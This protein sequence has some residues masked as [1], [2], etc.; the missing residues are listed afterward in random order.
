MKNI[1]KEERIIVALDVDS[2][3]KEKAL[4]ETLYPRVKVF[5]IGFQLFTA[6]GPDAVRMVVQKGA[7]VF[8]DLK[9]HDIPHTVSC[10]IRE[11][12]KLGAAFVD[13]HIHG[14]VGMMKDAVAAAR[15]QARE[16]H[17]EPPKLIGVTVLTSLEDKELSDLGIRKNVK[18]Q[19]LYLAQLAQ[20]AGLDGV[21][22]SAQEAQAIRWA[23]GEEFII[24][25]PGIRL[26]RE[27]KED[28]KRT[29]TPHEA[30]ARGSDYIVV[31]RS[32]VNAEN[33]CAAIDE[34]L[35]SL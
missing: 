7:K 34:A 24:I 8:L 21:V 18:S 15:A 22:A 33:P 4:L 12:V 16:M 1:P 17:R 13:M 20:K 9:Y 26:A 25:T 3:E 31:G 5:K 35:T 30:F 2:R 19:V 23:C 28:Q 32:I 10:A 27:A 6:C 11:S 14:G 29:M